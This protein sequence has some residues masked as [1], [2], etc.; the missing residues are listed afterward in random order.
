MTATNQ[1]S[2]NQYGYL[3]S[4][5]II[6]ADPPNGFTGNN[7][8]PG[9]IITNTTTGES[10]V[11]TNVIDFNEI[12]FSETL[13]IGINDDW[14]IGTPFDF[15]GSIVSGGAS[16]IT[17]G[18]QVGHVINNLTTGQSATITEVNSETELTFS[19][20]SYAQGGIPF[21]AGDN[22]SITD[23]YEVPIPGGNLPPYELYER[24]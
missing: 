18:V 2:S 6:F 3:S 19:D 20:L 12:E 23:T 10:G 11:I 8:Q 7:I 21:N 15:H 4:L 14:T 13:F 22:F 1:N 16:F 17:D 5:N 24:T 9:M